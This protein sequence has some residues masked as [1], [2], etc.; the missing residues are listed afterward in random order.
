M[1]KIGKSVYLIALLVIFI[2]FMPSLTHAVPVS[3]SCCLKY[4]CCCGCREVNLSKSKENFKCNCKLNKTEGHKD[5]LYIGSSPIKTHK[6]NANFI[7]NDLEVKG[8]FNSWY[9]FE[10][11]KNDI[12][13]PFVSLFLLNSS[14]L[15]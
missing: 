5:T 9:R 11:K 3:C 7:E 2:S 15:L 1:K 12:T 10:P 6:S 13:S 14:F 8:L 4:E